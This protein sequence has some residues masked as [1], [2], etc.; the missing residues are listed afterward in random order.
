MLDSEASTGDTYLYYFDH[1]PDI[2]GGDKGMD[3]AMDLSYTFGFHRGF[4]DSRSAFAGHNV[5]S[6]DLDLA[7]DFRSL[8]T[9]FAKSG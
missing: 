4:N 8:L 6:A 3:H 7:A 1:Y 2:P 9:N 5:S